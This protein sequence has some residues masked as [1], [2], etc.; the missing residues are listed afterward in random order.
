MEKFAC[1]ILLLIAL[2]GI[3]LVI[4]NNRYIKTHYWKWENGIHKFENVPYEIGLAN[5][6][7]SHTQYGIRYDIVPELQTFNFGLEAQCY[8]YDY[9][10]MKQY[11]S[12]FSKGATIII[13]ISY[14]QI[15]K[16]MGYEMTRPRYYRFMQKELMDSWSF[17][18]SLR[19]AKFP[20]LSAGKNIIHIFFDTPDEDPLIEKLEVR[21]PAESVPIDAETLY[22]TYKRASPEQGKKDYNLN[23]SEVYAL[24]DFCLEHS[25]RPVLITV[26]LTD[27]FN[28][29]YARIDG[30]SD[31]FYQF[32]TEICQKYTPPLH[33]LDYSSE[34]SIS[35]DYSLFH[36]ATHLNSYG[37]EKFTKI[38]IADLKKLHLLP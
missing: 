35:T 16:R 3:V 31:T 20:I 2:L 11:I 36:D 8:F 30:F 29:R 24:I 9:A 1:K 25:L 12:H 33:Y 22:K 13:P 14:F 23:L 10:L 26:P 4:L 15:D 21:V 34:K 37:A 18:D 32:T 27:A 7:S 5:L 38:L 6:G 19:Y 17:L 28:E